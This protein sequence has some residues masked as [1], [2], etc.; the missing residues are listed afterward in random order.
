MP[1]CA[2]H[3]GFNKRLM[4]EATRAEQAHVLKKMKVDNPG[5][6]LELLREFSHR[7]PAKGRPVGH[8]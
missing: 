4:Q 8:Q 6:Y 7:E 3:I 2:V 1:L 5:G